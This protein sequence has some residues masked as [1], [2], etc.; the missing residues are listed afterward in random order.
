MRLVNVPNIISLSRL[1]LAPVFVWLIANSRFEECFYL[2]LIA[3]ASDMIDGLAAR[4]MG[5]QTTLGKYLDPIADKVLL[6]TIYVS[7][8]IYH[9]LPLWIVIL[10]VFR[11]FLIFGG[12]LLVLVFNIEYDIRPLMISKINTFLQILLVLWLF[13]ILAQFEFLRAG[14]LIGYVDF[15]LLY[16]MI[17]TLIWSGAAYVIKWINAIN[18]EQITHENP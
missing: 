8:G 18:R 16:G 5:D 17:V 2:C 4:A 10:V 13:G 11:D 6:A 15:I 1:F 12:A 3:G 7:L 14:Q 9:L